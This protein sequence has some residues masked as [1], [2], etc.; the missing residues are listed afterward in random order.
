M[1][2]VQLLALDARLNNLT[3]EEILC[4]CLS[5]DYEDHTA[6]ELEAKS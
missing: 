1:N 5:V 2:F 4:L 6:L 3:K